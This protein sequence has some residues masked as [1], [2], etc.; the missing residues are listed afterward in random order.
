MRETK[1]TFSYLLA[2]KNEE[3]SEPMLKPS[4]LNRSTIFGQAKSTPSKPLD[5]ITCRSI[6]VTLCTG[7][8]LDRA[9]INILLDIGI[10]PKVA[11]RSGDTSARRFPNLMSNAM[12]VRPYLSQ[13]SGMTIK[14]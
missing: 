13:I 4:P 2:R 7:F 6:W 3:S 8:D 12:S 11:A 1:I 10:S 9:K 14:K 5:C